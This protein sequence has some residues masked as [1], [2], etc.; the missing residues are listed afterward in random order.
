MERLKFREMSDADREVYADVLDEH[1]LIAFTDDQ[2]WIIE[3]NMLRLFEVHQGKMQ[4]YQ[5]FYVLE[6]WGDPAAAF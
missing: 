1:A 2:T 5:Q 4:A 6:P 3:G